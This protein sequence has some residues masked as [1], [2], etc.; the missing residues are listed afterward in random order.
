[1]TNYEVWLELC[2]GLGR[3]PG[4]PGQELPGMGYLLDGE[5]KDK[6]VPDHA[7]AAGWLISAF[8]WSASDEGSEYWQDLYNMF[9]KTSAMARD[10]RRVARVFRVSRL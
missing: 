9:V 2:S 5:R 3:D 7:I 6:E 8:R 10:M 4:L 1:M